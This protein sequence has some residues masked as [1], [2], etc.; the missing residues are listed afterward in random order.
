[1]MDRNPPKRKSLLFIQSDY[2]LPDNNSYAYQRHKEVNIVG[3]LE[4]N[5]IYQRRLAIETMLTL[6]IQKHILVKCIYI[7]DSI[8]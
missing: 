6:S 7:S 5:M 8:S 1:M 2:K 3:Y 4:T